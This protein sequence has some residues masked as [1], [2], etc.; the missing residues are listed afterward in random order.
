MIGMCNL[1]IRDKIDSPSV[2][3]VEATIAEIKKLHRLNLD[4]E[5]TE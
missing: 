3:E 4:G 5:V 1:I 2:P